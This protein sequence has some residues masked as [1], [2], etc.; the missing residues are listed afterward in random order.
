MIRTALAIVFALTATAAAADEQAA[1]AALRGGGHVALM[2]HATAPGVGDPATFKLGDCSTQRN[3]NDAGRAEARAI[4]ERFRAH[5]VAVAEVRT[6][7]W[8]RARDTAE[9]MKLGSVTEDPRLNSFFGDG[10]RAGG[11]EASKAAVRDAVRSGSAAVLVTH[12]VNVTAATGV[13]PASGE[14]V[15]VTVEGD[16]IQVVGRI[17]P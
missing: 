2:R 1:W 7:Q 3:L 8:C 17:A 12:Q 6:S 11:L 14:I 9:E 13:F 10:D 15:V 5:G 16:A 4:G